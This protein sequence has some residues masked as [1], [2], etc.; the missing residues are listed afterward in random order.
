MKVLFP[1]GRGVTGHGLPVHRR[2][3]GLA[4]LE[5]EIMALGGTVAAIAVLAP[6]SDQP[7]LDFTIPW[8]VIPV[9]GF[10]VA[11]GHGAVPGGRRVR[12]VVG[13]RG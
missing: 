1:N 6:G 4:G 12:R 2:V 11:G 9:P 10:L 3:S 5:H 13:R 8:A 7:P